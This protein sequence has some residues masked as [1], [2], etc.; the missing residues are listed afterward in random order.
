M[1]VFVKL[2]VWL[3]YQSE[4]DEG[5]NGVVADNPVLTPTLFTKKSESDVSKAANAV[6]SV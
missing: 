1:V 4:T 5:V 6:P 2:K 3:S